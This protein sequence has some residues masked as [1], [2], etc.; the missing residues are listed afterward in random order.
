M[1]LVVGFVL[2][3]MVS[4]GA[5]Y[6]QHYQEYSR[7]PKVSLSVTKVQI[8]RD[9]SGVTMDIY[10]QNTGN[11]IICISYI[12]L[13]D[14]NASTFIVFGDNGTYD[15]GLDEVFPLP[16]CIKPG[17]TIQLGGYHDVQTGFEG[18]DKVRVRIY[19]WVRG[20]SLP[21][22][23]DNESRYIQVFTRV[24]PSEG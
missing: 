10:I 24:L 7:A 5:Y 17:V 1:M 22:P 14:I 23:T 4:L 21:E 13:D 9:S 2:V 3:L 8:V 18:G 11:D 20:D 19:Y 16:R 6:V 12:R 15:G